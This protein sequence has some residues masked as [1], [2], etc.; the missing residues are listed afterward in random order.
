M[1]WKKLLG[2]VF[3]KNK[4]PSITEDELMVIVDEVE[5][6][7]VIEKHESD[8]IKSAI[9]FEDICVREILRCV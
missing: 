3:H 4:N 5:S 1:L 2:R 6:E 9:E 8:L 7:G